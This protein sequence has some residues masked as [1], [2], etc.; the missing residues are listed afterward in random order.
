MFDTQL[1]YHANGWEREDLI[2]A[3]TLSAR[4]GY[5]GIEVDWEMVESYMYRA[6]VF[7]EML[8]H[9]NLELAAVDGKLWLV[10]PGSEVDE[11]SRFLSMGRFALACGCQVI[12]VVP[13]RRWPDSRVG[14]EEWESLV[15]FANDTGK[16]LAAMGALLTLHPEV[17]TWVQTRNEILRIAEDTDAEAVHVCLDTAHLTDARM[18]PANTY[19]KLASRVRHVHLKDYRRTHAGAPY[20]RR[21]RMLGEGQVQLGKFVRKLETAGYTGWMVSEYDFPEAG[22][23][24]AA[25]KAAYDYCVE[26]LDLGL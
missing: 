15:R 9:E 1:G 26:K 18:N 19:A 22:A 10:G 21:L 4:T 16:E 14:K 13:P 20:A 23:S 24:A 7:A 3:M 25:A 11:K 6:E 12:V 8:H 17:E 5:R 2:Q